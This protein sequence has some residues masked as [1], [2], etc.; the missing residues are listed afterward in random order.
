MHT[1]RRRLKRLIDDMAAQGV[2]FERYGSN[3]TVTG[4]YVSGTWLQ[5]WL[6]DNHAELMVILPDQTK[7]ERVSDHPAIP[8]S[9]PRPVTGRLPM[10]LLELAA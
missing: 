5:R 6:T 10:H 8:G 1:T 9:R 2:T 3:I 4:L 7:P